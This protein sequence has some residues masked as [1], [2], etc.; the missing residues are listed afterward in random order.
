MLRLMLAIVS[1]FVS[2]PAL[3][4][5][6]SLKC[7]W[8]APFFISLD[9][10]AGRAVFESPAGSNLKGPIV[11][12]SN[13]EIE[14]NIMRVGESTYDVIW[15]SRTNKLTWSIAGKEHEQVR[16]YECARTALRPGL[17]NYDKIAP[18]FP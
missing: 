17:Q 15:N 5:Q 13:D 16:I 4:E 8:H 1:I 14:F 18:T 11:R 12:Q 7:E 10:D 2:F 9:T 3:A 6:F